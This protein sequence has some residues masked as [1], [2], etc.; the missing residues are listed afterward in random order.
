MRVD[1][2]VS[3]ALFVLSEELAATLECAAMGKVVR[4]V[5]ELLLEVLLLL[6]AAKDDEGVI[7]PAVTFAFPLLTDKRE[8]GKGAFVSVVAFAF[9]LFRDA[10]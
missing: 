6:G 10:G 1:L 8:A 5:S 2:L 4:A 9:A 3:R 7:V